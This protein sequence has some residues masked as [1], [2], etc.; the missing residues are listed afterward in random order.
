[1]AKSAKKKPAAEA[2]RSRL[3][4][5]KLRKPKRK[6]SALPKR[7]RGAASAAAAGDRSG[8]RRCWTGCGR[9]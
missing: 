1:M 6:P 8:G 7:R 5:K 3:K 9:W 2:R 4:P